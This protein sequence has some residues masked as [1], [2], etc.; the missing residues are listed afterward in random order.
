MTWDTKEIKRSFDA[1]IPQYFN[2]TSDQYEVLMGVNGAARHILYGA[3][4]SPISTT[5][6]K[7]AVRASE[8]ETTIGT[9]LTQAGYD[10][11]ANIAL[12]ALRDALLGT[13]NK[14]ITDL[15]T[16]LA[17]IATTAKQDTLAGLVATAANQTMIQNLIGALNASA[18]TDPTS[19]T[20]VLIALIKGLM[21][22]MQGNGSGSMPISLSG[23]KA[24]LVNNKVDVTAAV[25]AGS[26]EI[27]NTLAAVGM[28]AKLEWF[29][30]YAP[31]V[32]GATSGTHRFQVGIGG[33][34]TSQVI[35]DLSVN[36]NQPLLLNPNSITS[37]LSLLG[38]GV[39]FGRLESNQLQIVYFNNTDVTQTAMRNYNVRAFEEA[40]F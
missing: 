11:K 34:D 33:V 17:S 5:G 35:A 39:H 32:T 13:G 27:V 10:A 2:P 1:P 18:V 31:A 4:G 26:Y 22:Q 3:D 12:T 15:V 29:Y 8:L 14:T 25:A 7:L 9:M 37:A 40:V 28:I 36:Y 24:G 16:S 38:I 23:R 20:A 19:T 30:A 21:K 6:N